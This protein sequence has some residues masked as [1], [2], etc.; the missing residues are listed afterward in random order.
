MAYDKNSTCEIVTRRKLLLDLNECPPEKEFQTNVLEGVDPKEGLSSPNELLTSEFPVVSRP[1]K[2]KA[3]TPCPF[4]KRRGYCLKGDSCDFLHK[5]T[6]SKVHGQKHQY[7]PFERTSSPNMPYPNMPYPN[8]Y[9]P[10]VPLVSNFFS[11]NG[12]PPFWPQT[13]PFQYA[14][15]PSP[16]II[17]MCPPCPPPLP[18]VPSFPPASTNAPT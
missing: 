5:P 11:P 2:S 14:F 13:R 9:L 3:M 17:P 1:R 7:P 4:L 16:M 15:P 8:N 10:S 18:Y 12:H 6:T